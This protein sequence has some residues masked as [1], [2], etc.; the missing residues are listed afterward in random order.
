[1]VLNFIFVFSLATPIGPGFLIGNVQTFY[2]PVKP[3]KCL[4]S[5]LKN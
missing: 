3:L 4:A 5:F 2:R 1:M